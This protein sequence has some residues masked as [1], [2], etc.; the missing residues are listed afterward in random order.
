[1][2]GLTATRRIREL[3]GERGGQRTPIVAL[4]AYARQ[5]DI[6]MSKEAGCDFHLSKP[7]SKAKLVKTIAQYWPGDKFPSAAT[8]APDSP[9]VENF[10]DLVPDYL[11]ARR[12]E[13][14]EMTDLLMAADFRRLGFLAHNLKGSGLSYGF[15]VLTRLGRELEQSATDSNTDGARDLIEQLGD[16]LRGIDADRVIRSS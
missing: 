16:C 11:A 10:D 3:E 6:D 12:S 14:V 15:P 8:N 4:T 1:M 7:I 9:E 2:D 13:M 5:V